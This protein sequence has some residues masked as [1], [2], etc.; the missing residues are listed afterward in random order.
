MTLEQ[1]AA[2]AEEERA[3]ALAPVDALLS[4]LPLLN[5]H[6][7][8]ARRF[9]HGQRLPLAQSGMASLPAPGRVS[10]YRNSDTRLLGTAQLTEYGVLAPE[11][12]VAAG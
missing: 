4:S 5:L 9:L 1:L 12:L 6:D 8:L 11:R 10:V 3:A 2:L 7:E